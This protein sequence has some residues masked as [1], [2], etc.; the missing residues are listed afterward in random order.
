MEKSTVL[1]KALWGNVLFA[2][3][4][5][6][7]FLFFGNTFAFLDELAGGQRLL[8]GIEFLIMAG[9]A[10]Y[11]A[12]RPTPSRR[13][14]QVLIGLNI[15]LLV[16]SVDLLIWGPTVSALATEIRLMDTA[17]LTALIT[18]QVVGLRAAAPTKKIAL[19]P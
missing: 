8:F 7:A 5:A 3:L 6:I 19:I 12:L 15:C 18:A 4:S 17:V 14:V 10:T 2:E 1:Q 16:Y 11:A 13:L 9:L